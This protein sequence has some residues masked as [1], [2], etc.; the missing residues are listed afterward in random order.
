MEGEGVGNPIKRWEK[1]EEVVAE[2]RELAS[3]ALSLTHAGVLNQNG[4]SSDRAMGEWG[5]RAA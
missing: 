3:K 4:L 5:A 2:L 1:L